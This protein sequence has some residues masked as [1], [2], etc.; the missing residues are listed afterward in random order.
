MELVL[1]MMYQISIKLISTMEQAM[2]SKMLN[3][4]MEKTIMECTQDQHLAA[5]VVVDPFI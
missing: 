3:Q 5:C 2:R 4:Q 1:Q